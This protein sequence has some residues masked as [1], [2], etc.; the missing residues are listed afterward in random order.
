MARRYFGSAAAVGRRFGWGDPA[1]AKYDTEVVG[2][3]RD[4]L[5]GNLRQG[6]RP[7][8]D[9]PAAGGRYLIVRAGLPVSSM[10]ALVRREI[11]AVDANLDVDVKTVPQI[12][13]QAL[14]LE[15]LLA[16]LSGFF[17]A[18]ALLLAGVGLYGL[19]VYAVARRTREIGIRVALGAQR[20]RV[21]RQV[22]G[23]TLGLV[24]AGIL[25]GAAAASI[26]TRLIASTLFG[27]TPN[28][29][30]TL[31]RGD[32]RAGRRRRAVR[33]AAGAPR[34]GRRTLRRAE[35]RVGTPVTRRY[36][37]R[38]DG[39]PRRRHRVG[40]CQCRFKP[41]Q[42]GQIPVS[43]V[44]D[45]RQAERRMFLLLAFV[46]PL[47][48]LTGFGRTYYLK[49]LFHSPAVP[50]TLVH[51]HGLLMTAWI[52]LFVTQ[53][54]LISS[55]RVQTHRQLGLAGALLGAILIPVGLLTA[56]AAANNGSPNAPPNIP[57]RVFMIV[58]FADMVLFAIFFGGAVYYRRQP[59]NHKRLILLTVLNFFPPAIARLPL[60]F[61]AAGG[62]LV[63]FGLPD[64]AAIAL[65]IADTRKNGRLNRVFLDGSMPADRL[66]SAAPDAGRDGALAAI[67]HVAHRIAWPRFL[68]SAG[69]GV[70]TPAATGS[71]ALVAA[72]GGGAVPLEDNESPA[73]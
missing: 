49:G 50:S 55:R 20:G 17:G 41:W 25:A 18:A 68:T 67:R 39:S 7:L 36:C 66:S 59:A 21:V 45:R 2:V 26:A 14:V 54:G 35:T 23:E 13:D 65:L 5:Y 1:S 34:G 70:Q 53:V 12:L 4:A 58:P 28:D 61:V 63:F 64:L 15:R 60:A 48:V 42:E 10:A 9:Y 24:G 51:L 29:P 62:P 47:V 33:R 71:S 11:H 46:F 73:P 31:G 30:F 43:E 22:F 6:A 38:R 32:A 52:I 56:I 27:V 19:M 69:Y 57:P 8:I 3:A 16:R 40:Q 37:S 72:A 44:V